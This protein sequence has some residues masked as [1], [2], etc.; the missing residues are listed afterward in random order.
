M[1][2]KVLGIV[3][4]LAVL[5]ASFFFLTRPPK[6]YDS[7]ELTPAETVESYPGT[8]LSLKI[9]GH[10]LELTFQNGSDSWLSSGASVDQNQE[11]F[12]HGSLAVLLDGQ[13]YEVPQEDIATAG[14]GLELAPG[15]SV[16]GSFSFAGYSSLPDGLYRISFGYWAFDPGEN[17]PVNSN[18]YFE[19]YAEFEIQ[20]G[21][22]ILP[23]N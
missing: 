17:T 14:V 10:S 11:L 8:E 20:S 22:Y 7:T 5:L 23:S 19:S 6:P 16:S 15:D 21:K 13:W 2:K 9:D 1:Y 18:P 12:L 3:V 4:L